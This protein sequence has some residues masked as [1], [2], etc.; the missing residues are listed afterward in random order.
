MKIILNPDKELVK[1]IDKGLE[2]K[3]IK[4]GKKY[5]PCALINN[6][7]TICPCKEFREKRD[8]GECHCGKFIK[9]EG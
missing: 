2:D 9:V 3:K 6:E 4:Y 5:C 1:E 7:D 8:F